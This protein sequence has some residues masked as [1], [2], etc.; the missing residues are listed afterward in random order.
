MNPPYLKLAGRIHAE[1]G[2]LDKAEQYYNEAIALGWGGSRGVEGAWTSCAPGRG[3]AKTG[4]FG[5]GS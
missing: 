5:K 4:L 2:L 1:M 3:R